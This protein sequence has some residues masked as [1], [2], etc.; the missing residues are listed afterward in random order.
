MLLM[1]Q[2]TRAGHELGQMHKTFGASAGLCA[3]VQSL[4]V[5]RP[6]GAHAAPQKRW[7]ARA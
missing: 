2:G 6:T 4:P 5:A 3:V 7:A 1:F